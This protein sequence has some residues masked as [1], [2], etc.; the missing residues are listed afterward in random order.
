MGVRYGRKIHQDHCSASQ[1]C[2]VIRE[3][4]FQGLFYLHLTSRNGVFI[5]HTISSTFDFQHRICYT[6]FRIL[7][8]LSNLERS[9]GYQLPLFAPFSD[10]SHGI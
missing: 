5:L 9:Q 1:V 2:R 4:V 10:V 7:E 6:Y 3:S 8:V